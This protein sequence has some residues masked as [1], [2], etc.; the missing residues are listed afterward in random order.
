MATPTAI[1]LLTSTQQH[2]LY[3]VLGI[4]RRARKGPRYGVTGAGGK[5]PPIRGALRRRVGREADQRHRSARVGHRARSDR[6][7]RGASVIRPRGNGIGEQPSIRHQ[8]Q[9]QRHPHPPVA[10]VLRQVPL[11]VRPVGVG[12]AFPPRGTGQA[13]ASVGTRR[14]IAP[15]ASPPASPTGR[16]RAVGVSREASGPAPAIPRSQDVRG[17]ASSSGIAVEPR[18]PISAH[19][20]PSAGR[21][22]D[23]FDSLPARAGLCPEQVPG[24]PGSRSGTGPSGGRPVGPRRDADPTAG[25]PLRSGRGR[26]GRGASRSGTPLRDAP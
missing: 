10:M 21:L 7:D 25:P 24:R 11:P 20:S 17:P 12:L 26:R 13:E 6:P 5:P 23:H 22:C 18:L 16:C 19:T 4:F 2:E 3:S 8:S 9:R 15:T 14:C 1:P